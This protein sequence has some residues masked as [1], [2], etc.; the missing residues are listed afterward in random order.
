MK[1]VLFLHFVVCPWLYL[2]L[3]RI[4]TWCHLVL[5]QLLSHVLL[6]SMHCGTPDFPDL[7]HLLEFAQTHVHL[8][9]Y[10]P[11]LLLHSVFPASG[12]FAMSPLFASSGQ[13]FGT[14]ASASVLPMNI[15]G[16]FPLGLTGL[17]SLQSKK[18]SS[19]QHHSLKASILRYLTFFNSPTLTSIHDYWKSRNFDYAY[20]CRQSNVSAFFFLIYFIYLFF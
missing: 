5:G 15:Q 19:L 12:S 8:M 14:S 11:L 10:H 9:L 2:D 1:N 6:M 4:L 3:L 7:Y 20:L 16:W 18:I 13:S 17:I